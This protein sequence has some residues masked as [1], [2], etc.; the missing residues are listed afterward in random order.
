MESDK[1]QWN[2]AL[3]ARIK[4]AKTADIQATSV[5]LVNRPQVSVKLNVQTMLTATE[6]FF[7]NKLKWQVSRIIHLILQFYKQ[8]LSLWNK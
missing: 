3:K 7:S 8:F 2:Y 6:T 4:T 1:K 5:V